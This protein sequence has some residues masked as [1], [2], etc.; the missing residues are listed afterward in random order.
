MFDATISTANTLGN[1]LMALYQSNLTDLDKQNSRNF[2]SFFR[3]DPKKLDDQLKKA[4]EEFKN[5]KTVFD[6]C[7]MELNEAMQLKCRIR[8]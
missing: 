6:R 4:L 5:F 8:K 1:S 2:F 3:K 7:S